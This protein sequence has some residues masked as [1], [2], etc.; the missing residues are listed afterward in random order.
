MPS[1]RAPASRAPRDAAAMTPPRPPVTTSCPA[2]AA[3][4]P[5]SAAASSSAASSVSP[6]PTTASM[7]RS[8]GS[9]LQEADVDVPLREA[10]PLV[11]ANGVGVHLVDVEHALRQSPSAQVLQAAQ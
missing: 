4:R 10:E 8:L 9:A 5:T 1:T 11:G 7:L 2:N 3:S 6:G